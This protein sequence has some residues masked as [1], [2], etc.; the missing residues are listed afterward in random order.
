MFDITLA[1][2]ETFLTTK[3]DNDVIGSTFSPYGCLVA[4]TLSFLYPGYLWSVGMTDAYGL[5]DMEV[6]LSGES[7]IVH[8]SHEIVQLIENFDTC[9]PVYDAQPVTKVEW[10]AACNK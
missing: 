6:A 10:R 1:D 4:N 8:F 2:I 9:T 3:Q 5:V 7:Q